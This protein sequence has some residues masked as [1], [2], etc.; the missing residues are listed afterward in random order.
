METTG[1]FKSVELLEHE[2]SSA[3]EVLNLEIALSI[4]E[5]A[6]T[7]G[8]VRELPITIAIELDG[9]EVFRRPLPGASDEH[10]GWI[11]RKSNV[12]NLTHHSTMYERVKA[13]EEESDWHALHG[14]VDETHAI[15]GGG[16]PLI[17]IDGNFRGVLLISGLPQVDDHLFA[18][19]VL[20]G[21]SGANS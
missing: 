21:F 3:L 2:A 14:V 7:L 16:F 12:V 1:N 11:T 20:K 13:E 15:H 6:A 5:S 18:V 19:E 8:T 17:T 9:S 10:A 4:G